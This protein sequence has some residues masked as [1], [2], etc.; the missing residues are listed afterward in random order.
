[1]DDRIPFRRVVVDERNPPDPHCKG[2]GDMDGDG[3]VDLL[4]ASASCGG[5]FW[6]RAPTWSKHPIAPGCFTTDMAVVDM[7]G[8][9]APDVVI[10]SRE[11]LMLYRNPRG[12]G[13][14]PAAG[15]WP[16]VNIGASGAGMHDVEVGDLDGDGRPDVVTRHQSGFGQLLGNRIHLW[17]QASP[18]SW[19]H[20]DF[21]CAHGEGLGLSDLDRNGNLDV[22]IGGTWFENPG[23]PFGAWIPHHFVD[24]ARFERCWTRGDVMVAIGDV[25]GD[26][27]PEIVLAPSEGSGMLAWYE[28][29]A[30]VRE[31]GWK[32]HIVE[33]R[34]DH[35]HGLQLAD[36]DG[37]GRLDLVV[38]KMHQAS[39]PQDVAI[40]RNLGGGRSWKREVIAGSGSHGI[41]A[42][43]LEGDG[44]ISVYGANWNDASSTHGALELWLNER[45][46]PTGDG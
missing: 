36:V 45:L 4:A 32:E 25:N 6:Y 1:M 20:A 22:V 34:I 3:R 29:P 35:A 40:Y 9:G 28:A 46:I 33:E 31:R 17:V 5:L 8:D 13:G 24:P 27:R 18:V 7:D 2:V 30:D 38:A 42:V 43:D 37:D 19:R 44:R 15:S 39:P 16:A 26:G 12:S 23:D 11:G 14:D 41:R 21:P 10:P